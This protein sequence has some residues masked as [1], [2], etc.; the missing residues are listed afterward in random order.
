MSSIPPDKVPNTTK[1]LKEV[2]CRLIKFNKRL[3]D[4]LNKILGDKIDRVMRE[5]EIWMKKSYDRW[6]KFLLLYHNLLKTE[7]IAREIM[8]VLFQARFLLQYNKIEIEV[9]KLEKSNILRHDS[10]MISLTFHDIS[11]TKAIMAYSQNEIIQAMFLFSEKFDIIMYDEIEYYINL[12]NVVCIRL[13]L[14][15]CDN[16][17]S[18]ILNAEDM[19][20]EVEDGLYCINDVF[21]SFCSIYVYKIEYRIKIYSMLKKNFITII[22]EKILNLDKF[23]FFFKNDVLK[24]TGNEA[25]SDEYVLASLESYDFTG[26]KEWMQIINPGNTDDVS[27]TIQ[28][29]R[30]GY[31]N[32]FLNLI[33]DECEKES[34]DIISEYIG[35][36]LGQKGKTSRIC[37]LRIISKFLKMYYNVPNWKNSIVIPIK[38]YSKHNT[39]KRII[40]S[41]CPLILQ[42][43]SRFWVYDSKN[44]YITDNIYVA[45]NMWFFIL[46]FKYN[47]ILKEYDLSKITDKLF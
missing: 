23:N 8:S 21:R 18:D 35:S 5:I 33:K 3:E 31:V 40:K 32:E 27:K 4:V 47:S 15:F 13:G 11:N 36:T 26:D 16:Y 25:L 2:V 22:P 37:V 10:L 45:V 12:F 7:E 19:R 6:M 41:S 14:L 24:F 39:Q 34:E 38:N 46:K 20:E 17:S 9:N 29:L 28:V 44:I 43:I 30:E 42:V 1:R